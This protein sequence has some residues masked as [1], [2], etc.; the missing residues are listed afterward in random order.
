MLATLL[1]VSSF[2]QTPAPSPAGPREKPETLLLNPFEVVGDRD[3]SY[4]ALNS[5]SITAFNVELEKMPVSAEVLNETLMTDVGAT[6]VQDLLRDYA[7]GTGSYGGDPANATSNGGANDRFDGQL[8]IRGLGSPTVQRDTFMPGNV[9]VANVGFTSNFDIERVEVINGPQSLLYGFSGAGGAINLVPKRA[10][11]NSKLS[12]SLRFQLDQFGHKQGTFDIGAGSRNLSARLV[13]TKQ[14]IG[15]RR[16]SLDHGLDGLYGQI[17]FRLFDHTVVRLSQ[18]FVYDDRLYQSPPTLTARN[19]T[20]DAR[21][22]LT[23]RYLLATN[24]IQSAA[25][26]GPSGAGPLV[27][28]KLKWDNVDSL[29]GDGYH[30]IDQAQSQTMTIESTWSRFFSTQISAG[31]ASNQQEKYGNGLVS[32]LAPNAAANPTGTWAVTPNLTDFFGRTRAKSFRVS[33]VLT[34]E[35]LGGRARSQT[36]FGADYINTIFNRRAQT[37]VRADAS[38]NPVV[39]SR[40]NA[41]N[42]GYSLLGN[43]YVP[44][45]NGPQEAVR[46]GE[47][48]ASSISFN[49][50]NYAYV[51]TNDTRP[52]LISAS[53]PLGLTGYGAGG[54]NSNET[55]IKGVYVANFTTWLDGRLTTLAGMRAGTIRARRDDFGPVTAPS[56][57]NVTESDAFSFNLGAN[58]ALRDWLRPYVSVS[59]S[60]LPPVT[61]QTD[62]YGELP[63]NSKGLGAEVGV[64]LTNRARTIS[65][66][67]AL[68]GASS[69]DEQF[70]IS[71]PLNGII[72]P[73][74]LNG[75]YRTPGRFVSGERRSTGIQIAATASPTR[76]WRLRFSG[77]LFESKLQT[78][79]SYAQFYN[80]QFYANASGQV[81]YRDG[82]VVYVTPAAVRVVP[83]GTSGAVPLTIATLNNPGSVYYA[84]PTADSA[85]IN[86]A[87]GAATALRTV[88]PVHGPI[89]TGAAGQ[90]ISLLQ[91]APNP[92]APPPGVI[93]V[94]RQGDRATGS[95]RA[96]F[97]LTSIYDFSEGLLRGLRLG[98]T[99]SKTWDMVSYYY[100][101]G[102]TA[103]L[104]NRRTFQLPTFL[105]VDGILGYEFKLGRYRVMTQLNVTN[106]FNRY[107]VVLLPSVTTG[108]SGARGTGVDARFNTEPRTYVM[109]ATLHF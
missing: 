66:S 85:R 96:S 53:N 55:V 6:S 31:Y 32:V 28:G 36:S 97:N 43:Y 52:A 33:G 104:A 9:T 15:T 61:V 65:G 83:E 63:G 102:S 38:G 21:H 1:G 29:G 56:T 18:Y 59:S 30:E 54:H 71:G 7:A 68:F 5:N 48:G 74:G 44:I 41:A 23:L 82:A 98:G 14:E 78:E 109:S 81:T 92:A 10:R 51:G 27:N 40:P 107:E 69:S 91:I 76:N 3:R 34:N 80:D 93:V 57:R 84:N 100:Y 60:N 13:A 12:G 87:S 86:A 35:L 37:Y 70:Q 64:K 94:S 20:D 67:V 50:V 99:V 11:F 8:S 47:P 77:A 16:V 75:T 17:A 46:V 88:D 108:Y 45:P 106:L 72:N 90:P 42:N 19:A 103:D 22:G 49:G 24:Q 101:E 2:A 95:P 58:Y 25:N 39:D 79:K 62:P 26:G 89:L 4:G 105:R 73:E